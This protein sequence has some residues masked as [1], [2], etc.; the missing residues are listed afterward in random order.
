MDTQARRDGTDYVI[1]GAKMWI[2]FLDVAS[3]YLTFAHLGVDESTGRKRICAF[4]ID[5]DTKGV[6]VHPLKNKYGFRPLAT[7]ELVLDNVRVPQEAL[8]GE[9][10]KGFEIA[11]N[12]VE[13][14][15]LGVASRAVGLAQACVDV[16]TDYARERVVFKQPIGKFQM[17]QEMLSD[18]IC[19]VEGARLLTYR[20][21][22]LKDHGLRARDAASIAKMTASDVAL[23][24]ATNAFQIHGAYGV[25]DEYPVARY[26]RDAKV[27]QIVE[28]N[29]QLHK[30]LVAE[31]ALGMR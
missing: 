19:G 2:S 5:A 14:G 29:N 4:L 7:G 28:G 20:L 30:A 26:L 1:D 13:N 6:S 16:A 15:R 9:E 23:E 12:A 21:A 8:L 24:A 22:Y 25:S 10:G 11:M 18:M 3:F 17:V 27:F 31:A